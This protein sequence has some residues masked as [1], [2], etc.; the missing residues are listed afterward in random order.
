M[1]IPI[2]L[3]FGIVVPDTELLPYELIM[4]NNYIS[5]AMQT[6]SASVNIIMYK[7]N[8][9]VFIRCKRS[10]RNSKWLKPVMYGYLQEFVISAETK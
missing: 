2:N 3:N 1:T 4:S 6:G 8:L 7:Y 5:L 10:I 9:V